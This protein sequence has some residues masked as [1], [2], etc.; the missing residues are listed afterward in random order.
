MGTRADFYIGRGLRAEWIGSIAWDGYPNNEDL[1]DVIR[2]RSEAK[3]RRSVKALETR[4]DFTSPSQ[5]WPWPWE[6]SHL[7]DY[8]Y[9]YEEGVEHGEVWATCF[10]Y[11][12]F[13]PLR[14]Q[15][16]WEEDGEKKTIFPQMTGCS[17]RAG[18]ARSG[19][20]LITAK[21]ESQE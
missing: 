7:T 12:W 15:P 20:M 3:F 19:V 14:P 6:N 21:K 17:A 11:D 2:A 8:A 16:E 5:G 1:G 9:A 10:G 13:D 18:S 4:N